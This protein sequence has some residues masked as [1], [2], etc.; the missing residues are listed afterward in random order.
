MR[1]LY[2]LDRLRLYITRPITV[3]VRLILTNDQSIL[4]VKHTYQQ[5]WYLPGGG[6]KK[7]ETLE[8]TARREMAEEVGAKLGRLR[9]FG[10]YT[11]FYEYKNT[12]AAMACPSPASG[13]NYDS[14]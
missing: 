5:H 11:N 14:S 10:V 4:L 1:L 13:E 6:V 9:L 7:G 3:G 8:Q 2:Q 12:R